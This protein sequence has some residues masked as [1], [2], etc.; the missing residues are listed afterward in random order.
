VKH[1]ARERAAALARQ[2]RPGPIPV[3]E[4]DT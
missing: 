1:L 4:I 3:R 2:Q